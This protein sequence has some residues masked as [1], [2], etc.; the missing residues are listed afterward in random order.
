M[1]NTASSQQDGAFVSP[2]LFG[3]IFDEVPAGLIV[4]DGS[5]RVARNNRAA[6]S[7]LGE[8][9]EGRLWREII[10]RLF[11]LRP[12][13]GHEVSLRNGRRVLEFVM[14]ENGP[15]FVT[16]CATFEEMA[17]EIVDGTA[18]AKL[19]GDPVLPL[20]FE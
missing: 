14:S 12:D 15:A 8:A 9:L 13:D 11:C 18:L 1:K 6:E 2:A 3:E 19:N 4:L 7:L 5:G 10:Q 17:T 20:R 16:D